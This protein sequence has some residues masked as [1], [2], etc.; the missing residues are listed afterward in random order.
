MRAVSSAGYALRNE[1]EEAFGAY[2]NDLSGRRNRTSDPDR[3]RGRF[4]I[5]YL[6]LMMIARIRRRPREY[7]IHFPESMRKNNKVRKPTARGAIHPLSII[8]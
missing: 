1:A 8:A 6:T 7:G 5:R 3:A 4:F 2:Q